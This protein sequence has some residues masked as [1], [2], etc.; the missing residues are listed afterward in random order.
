MNPLIKVSI[1][2]LTL[3]TIVNSSLLWLTYE[4]FSKETYGRSDINFLEQLAQNDLFIEG[5]I[6]GNKQTTR[7]KISEFI[8]K[9]EDLTMTPLCT[10]LKTLN[11]D[12][13]SITEYCSTNMTMHEFLASKKP[14]LSGTI[15]VM[16]K[17]T[18]VGEI[19]WVYFCPEPTPFLT[20]IAIIWV[21]ELLIMVYIFFSCQRNLAKSVTQATV[22]AGKFHALSAQ[23][24]HMAAIVADNMKKFPVTSEC[25]IMWYKHPYTHIMDINK[26]TQQLRGSITSVASA[27]Q[28]LC[29]MIQVSRST[30]VNKRLLPQHATLKESSSVMEIVFNGDAVE[31]LEVTKSYRNTIKRIFE[32]FEQ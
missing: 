15:P 26:K 5:V 27:A 30:Y 8:N 17:Q 3:V 10:Q 7:V 24:T 20:Y 12:D 4:E 31:P 13:V 28:L 2:A 29:P 18:R 19:S 9:H 25:L 1:L 21:V 14:L 16:D 11:S 32:E 22:G 6:A 23:T